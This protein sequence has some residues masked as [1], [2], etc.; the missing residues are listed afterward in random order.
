MSDQVYVRYIDIRLTIVLGRWISVYIWGITEIWFVII[1]GS[2]PPLRAYFAALLR[3]KSE[4]IHM[5]NSLQTAA[6]TVANDE[7]SDPH[8]GYLYH[9]ASRKFSKA[10]KFSKA[11]VSKLSKADFEAWES[12]APNILV[13]DPIHLK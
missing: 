2:L 3:L 8:D 13:L 6:V 11:D 4:S 7:E 1:L 10:G 9:G 12:R 5:D